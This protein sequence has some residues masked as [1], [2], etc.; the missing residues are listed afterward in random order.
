MNTKIYAK[1]FG[2]KMTFSFTETKRSFLVG[3]FV[4][5]DGEW[6]YLPRYDISQ[7]PPTEWLNSYKKNFLMTKGQ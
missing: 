7:Q 2:S 4:F 1:P 5:Q 6:Y 3:E